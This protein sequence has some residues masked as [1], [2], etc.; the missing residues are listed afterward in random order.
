MNQTSPLSIGEFDQYFEDLHGHPPFSWQRDLADEVHHQGWPDVIDIPTAGGKTAVIDIA[1]F[2]L[3]LAADRPWAV[4]RRIFFTVDRR[5]VVNQAYR[6]SRHIAELLWKAAAGEDGK[7][8]LSTVASN[9]LRI[10][11]DFAGHPPLDVHELRGGIYRDDAWVRTPLQ[12]AVLATTVDQVGSRMLFRGYGV[13]DRNLSIHAAMTGNDSLILLDEAH[14]SLPFEQTVDAVLRYR[15]ERWAGELIGAPMRFVRMSAT[16]ARDDKRIFQLTDDHYADSELLRK[17]HQ[18]SKPVRLVGDHKAKA[19]TP[20]DTVAATLVTEATDL[21]DGGCRRVAV[22]CNRVAVAREAHRQ[23]IDGGHTSDLMIGRMRPI[24]RDAQAEK[25][26]PIFES[27]GTAAVDDRPRFLVATQTIEVGVDFDFDAM[28]TQCASMDALTQRFGR[29]NRVGKFADARGVIVGSAVDQ[30]DQTNHSDDKPLDPIY[31][32]ASSATWHWLNQQADDE[33]VDFGVRVDGS[34]LDDRA[35]RPAGLTPDPIRAPVLMPAHLDLLVQTNPRPA[36]DPDVAHYLHGLTDDGETPNQE[37]INICWR[38]DL[39]DPPQP[40]AGGV[41][42]TATALASVCDDWI[43]AVSACPPSAAECMSVPLMQFRRWL[44][45]QTTR[46]PGGDIQHQFGEPDDDKSDAETQSRFG[47]VWRGRDRSIICVGRREAYRRLGANETIVLPTWLGGWNEFGHIPDQSN[48]PAA[49]WKGLFERFKTPV[50]PTPDR[51]KDRDEELDPS[52]DEHADGPETGLRFAKIDIADRAFAVR[53]L[54]HL[55]RLHD[56]LNLATPEQRLWNLIR[57]ELTECDAGVWNFTVRDLQ[58]EL[59]A[60]VGSEDAEERLGSDVTDWQAYRRERLQ[61]LPGR[62][63]EYPGGLVWITN[64]DDFLMDDLPP[65]PGGAFDDDVDDGPIDRPLALRQ[66]TADAVDV[67]DR[68][69]NGIGLDDS[70]A[71]VVRE[72]T[73]WHDV[74]KLDP[75]FQA[76]LWGTSPAMARLVPMALAKSEGRRGGIAHGLP[77]GFRHEYVSTQI[78]QASAQ[79]RASE[80]EVS[81]LG[82]HLID[83]HHG[84]A[85]P[86]PGQWR[87]SEAPPIDLSDLGGTTIGSDIRSSW[88]SPTDPGSGVGDR[89][90]QMNRQYGAWGLAYLEAL[91][92]LADWLASAE[93]HR[94]APTIDFSFAESPSKP[95]DAVSHLSGVV[96]LGP[97]GGNPF[98]F[99]TTVGL[100]RTL[101][102]WDDNGSRLRFGWTPAGGGWRP[103]V[104]DPMG[105]LSD[106]EAVLNACLDA[107]EVSGSNHPALQV[108]P[109]GGRREFFDRTATSASLNDRELAD[110]IACNGSDVLTPDANSQIQTS[111]RDYHAIAIDGILSQT[112]GRHLRR[113]LFEPWDYADPIAGVSLHLEPREDRRH[114]YQWHTPSGDPTRKVHGGMIGANRLALEAWPMFTSLPTGDRLSTVGFFRKRSLGTRLRWQL[115]RCGLTLPMVVSMLNQKTASDGGVSHW[116]GERPGA[117]FEVSRILVGKTPNFTPAVGW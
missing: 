103:W 19:K 24:D 112:S 53:G 85:R 111:R 70:L 50:T 52:S 54:K 106:E 86:L 6:R 33:T 12:P 3:A 81:G 5:L 78:F 13:S 80:A 21:V 66:H 95:Q 7:P 104:F 98:G 107:F 48:D 46:P 114:A 84:F 29:L 58:R 105:R 87:D 113:A 76:L 28:V 108:V 16:V 100:F 55:L 115:W 25:L 10:G 32:N 99:L 34:V 56:H 11:G 36:L 101:E 27:D 35:T 117:R 47:L 63:F 2:T 57:G 8:V 43:D 74:G 65:L 83:S 64:R 67:V 97:D 90:W 89:F 20:P 44:G 14:C 31:Q 26:T 17:R 23:L 49:D 116:K 37:T 51:T 4:P 75:R 77:E 72:S 18:A 30:T 41:K 62:W 71:S 96:C 94:V 102:R 69:L 68:Y 60:I 1:V 73:R 9:L 38:A 110:W 92:R 79:L 45:G 40:V 59:N 109:E 39:T 61:T 82:S 22:V 42:A 88:P 15:G 93:P 91:V